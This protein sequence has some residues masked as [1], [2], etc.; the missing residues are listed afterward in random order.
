[1]DKCLMHVFAR[2]AVCMQRKGLT[3]AELAT[4]G[5]EEHHRGTY[6]YIQAVGVALKRG[7]RAIDQMRASDTDGNE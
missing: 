4:N 1:M 3:F 6:N 2:C 5:D 7:T